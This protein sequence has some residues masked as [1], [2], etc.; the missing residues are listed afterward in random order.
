MAEARSP[1]GRKRQRLEGGAR[2]SSPVLRSLVRDPWT[3]FGALIVLAFIVVALFGP[4]MSTSD[5]TQGD[6]LNRLKPPSSQHI[7]G[8]DGLGRDLFVRVIHGARL[9]ALIGFLAVIAAG[10]VGVT[11]G[12][13]AGFFGGWVDTVVGRLVDTLLAFPGILLAI[14]ILAILGPGITSVIV[15][16][17]IFG[18]PTYARVMRGTVLAIS[19]SEYVEAAAALGVR[20]LSVLARHV[21]RNAWAP[22][23]V[24]SS[25]NFGTAVM[26]AS[27]LSF[28]GVG[29]QPPFPEWGAIIAD[30]RNYLRSAPHITTITGLIVFLTVLGFNLVGDGLRDALDP[31]T[32]KR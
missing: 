24:L 16:V 20:P 6:I 4:L 26:T 2:F 5:P 9:S 27:A 19:R 21:L 15:A 3:I 8:T 7:F 30:G 13:L 18:I 25:L 32:Q 17:G 1:L 14:L 10:V 23:L 11:L 31:R 22:V 12:A 29:V 28:L